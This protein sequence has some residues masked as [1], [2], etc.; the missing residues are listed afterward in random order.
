MASYIPH[1]LVHAHL[2]APPSLPVSTPELRIPTD[3]TLSDELYTEPLHPEHAVSVAYDVE[4]NILG[5]TI[6]NGYVLDLRPMGSTISKTRLPNSEGSESIRVFFP[7]PLRTLS[8]GLVRISPQE[9][10]LYILVVSQANIV[11][12]LNFPLGDFEPSSGE[13]FSF[14]LQ[15]GEQ[16]SE[17]W[18]VPEDVIGSCGGVGAT[19]VVDE[20]TVVLGGGDGGI[21]ILT[22]SGPYAPAFG[23]WQATHHRGSSMFR[24]PSLFS[25]SA[26]S[27]EQITSFA[28]YETRDNLRILY[29]LSRDKRL[30][31]WNVDTGS[32]LKMVDIRSSSQSLVVK[33]AE[34]PTSIDDNTVNQIRVVPHPFTT[35]RYSHLIVVFFSTPHSQAAAGSFVVYRVS[36]SGS[37]VN[38]LS[39]AGER[40]C[41]S[42]S[43]GSELRGLEVVAPSKAQGV[44]SGW[45]LWV[46][47]DREGSTFCET[48]PV[49]DIFQFTTYHAS[50]DSSLLSDWQPV[51]PPS[52]A[53]D[54]D[55]A[56]FDNLLSLQ[57]PNPAEPED[58]GDI[59]ATFIEHL[60]H[61]GRFS[62]S[63][64]Q[65]ALDDY[66]HLLSQKH[67]RVHFALP[68]A[69]TSLSKRFGAIVG[70]QV[71][72]Q[73]SQETGAVVVD[74]YRQE[75]KLEWLSV[76]ANVR[77]LDR[78]GRWPVTTAVVER[79][80]YIL[81]REGISVP[82]LEDDAGVVN[83]LAKEEIDADAFLA[84]PTGA[85]SLYS[86]LAAPGARLAATSI[87]L[88]GSHLSFVLSHT[89]VQPD[90]DGVLAPGTLLDV[91]QRTVGDTLGAGQGEAVEDIGA[92]LWDAFLEGSLSEEDRLRAREV[93]SKGDSVLR[94]LK[95]SLDMLEDTSFPSSQ[96]VPG[97]AFS[98]L[99]NALLTST[100]S[101][102]IASRHAFALHILL[103]S[104][105]LL[106]DSPPSEEDL[107]ELVPI[108][109]RSMTSYHRYR[110]LKWVAT[111]TGEE[112]GE[113]SSVGKAQKAQNGKKNSGDDGVSHSGEGDDGDGFG[114]KYSLLHS[115]FAHQ[116]PQE[117]SSS[118]H[119]IDTYLPAALAALTQIGLLS[120]DQ[121][122]LGAQASDVVL[123]NLIYAD[124]HPLLAGAFT[125]L[126]PL[127]SGI[128]YIKGRAYLEA[129]VVDGAVTFLERAAAGCRD[130]S[131]VPILPS[132]SGPNG[133]SAYYTHICETF[134]SHGAQE[135]VVRFG[136]LAIESA[137]YATG[138][139]E[140]RAVMKDLW[141]KVFMAN[142]ELSLYEEA[143]A[144]LASLPFIELKRDFLGHLISEM[145]ERNEVGR[146]NALGFIGL[147]RDVEELL[148]F[149]ARNSDPLRTPNYYKVLYSWHITRGDY[150]SS[151]EIMYLQ[152]RRFAEGTSSSRLPAFELTAMQA[153]S[154][155]A[156]INALSLIEKKNAWV[157]VPGVPNKSL[158]GIKRRRMTTYIPEEEFTA[159]KKPVDIITL[160]DIQAE[161]ALV[162]S[163]LRLSSKTPDLYDHGVVISPQETVGL[164]VQRGMYDVALSSAASLHVDMTDL[165]QSLAT[166]CVELSRLQEHNVDIN[167]AT[168]LQTSSITSRLQGPPAA[169]ALHY[170]RVSLSQH[171]SSKTN[172]RYR[173]AVAETLFSINH[174][175]KQG[176]RMP[177]WLV[178]WEMERDAEGWIGKAVRWGWVAEAVEWSLDLVRQATPPELLPKN[179]S[180]V[181]SLPYNLFDSVLAATEGGDEKDEEAVQRNAKMLRDEVKR[182]LE[183][184]EFF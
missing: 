35:S 19:T 174:D 109:A 141:T 75:L 37:G 135:A 145:C 118:N 87:A 105:F 44:N 146:L 115:I 113:R 91:F 84:L 72:P 170:L 76:W 151:G 54:F 77:E 165:F 125:D 117:A 122:D 130:N 106:C 160:E 56:Y 33:G 9:K 148:R 133:L 21:V 158:K 108:L 2:P 11:Y 179:K 42:L 93:L 49:D 83:R 95:Q 67:P 52:D 61:P 99:G 51:F 28:E 116:I 152:G 173:Q 70:A 172:F 155:L 32:F 6:Y 63:T 48:I 25:R 86:A 176:W 82:V 62:P 110:V 3:E 178:Q 66:I 57:P 97:A 55:A 114:V 41:S 34:V 20:R 36:T 149:K 10:R 15:N 71:H 164:F 127:S 143:Y 132:T 80:V 119:A 167:I 147:Q 1:H 159:G 124:D 183:A 184:L 121:T 23:E 138:N 169:L 94:G 89:D 14:T 180:N 24:L 129:D 96:S 161:Y 5:R 47:W 128:A 166:K 111:Q 104:L 120:E 177:S 162:L 103:A 27:S 4:N 92:G 142:L 29:T 157:S 38:E 58:N 43:A 12:R 26:N 65:T 45:R 100:L 101:D 74:V 163:R 22:R 39:V 156:A 150:K 73:V 50:H 88:A 126:Y 112:A 154:Y 136:K 123:G 134:R 68:Q 59:P 46:S 8:S 31:A 13:R 137:K 53:R 175:K 60:F 98:G 30:R 131:L 144:V 139:E 40:P 90:E 181:V 102:L 168:F 69:H 182:R 171:D 140:E 85:L 79:E 153:R 7:E 18:E 78:Q 81:T 107:E 64:L 16:W 17:E